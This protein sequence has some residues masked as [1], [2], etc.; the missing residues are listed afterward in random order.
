MLI[1]RSCRFVDD[2]GHPD[3]FVRQTF[4]QAVADNQVNSSPLD[5]TAVLPNL[6]AYVLHCS[7]SAATTA[8]E[9]PKALQ[10]VC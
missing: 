5:V 10:T 7:K 6:R 2:G 4:R 8:V 3:D 9:Q 1:T